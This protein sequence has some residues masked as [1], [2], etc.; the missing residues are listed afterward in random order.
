M[1][2]LAIPSGKDDTGLHRQSVLFQTYE[3]AEVWAKDYVQ[4]RKERVTAAKSP[5][6]A[7]R[8]NKAL[9]RLHSVI[10]YEDAGKVLVE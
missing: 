7:K 10:I 1:A 5:G 2:F 9:A 8:R 6:V 4:K 3:E